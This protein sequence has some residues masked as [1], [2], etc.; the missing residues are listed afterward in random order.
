MYENKN[1]KKYID[2]LLEQTEVQKNSKKL[3]CS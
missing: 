1:N 2:K 3:S